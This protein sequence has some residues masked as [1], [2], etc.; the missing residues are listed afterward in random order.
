MCSDCSLLFVEFELLL[1]FNNQSKLSASSDL[2]RGGP[3]QQ[4]T[5]LIHRSQNIHKYNMCTPVSLVSS[6]LLQTKL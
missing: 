3:K 6:K 2:L 1:S 5:H 4:T